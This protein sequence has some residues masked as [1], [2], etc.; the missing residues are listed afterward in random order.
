MLAAETDFFVLSSNM[1]NYR[2]KKKSHQRHAAYFMEHAATTRFCFL[3]F[4]ANVLLSLL[5]MLLLHSAV[6]IANGRAGRGEQARGAPGVRQVPL[7]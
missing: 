3:F 1:Y 2:N 5:N 4:S 6:F 7:H